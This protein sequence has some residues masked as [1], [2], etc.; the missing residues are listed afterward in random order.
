V[1]TLQFGTALREITPPYPAWLHGYADRDRPSDGVLEPT[2]LGCLAISNGGETA[3]ILTADMIGIQAHICQRLYGLLERATGIGYP[4]L[5][6]SCS[7]THFAPALHVHRYASPHVG[8]VDADPRFVADFEAKLVEAAQESLRNMQPGRLEG[9]RLAAPQVSFNRR[10]I[11][12]DGSVQTNF[13]YPLNPEA[14]TFSPTD[15]ELTVLRMRN[16]QGIG[17]VLCNFGCHPVT[18]GPSREG[19]HYRVSSDYPFYVRQVIATAYACPVFFTLGA[20][21]DAVPM[22]RY[23]DSRQRIGSILGNSAL[24]AERRYAADESTDIRAEAIT[25]AVDTIMETDPDLVEAEYEEARDGFLALFDDP[26]ADREG[27][28]YRTASA[29]FQEKGNAL[30]RSRLYPDNRYAIPVQFLKIGGTTLVGLPFEV[31]S[32]FSLRMKARFPHSVLVSCCG[33]Y[34]GYL[35]FAYEY[36]RGGYE[37]SARSTHFVPGT[38]DRLLEVVLDKLGNW[39]D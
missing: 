36:E 7:H 37:A 22:D 30:F 20:A 17:A 24:L 12:A 35:P 2:Y 28:A 1:G 6:L 29:S 23:G 19:D 10:T 14:Y 34:Q 21:G 15:T 33:G 26:D 5:L 38:A 32:E 13:R 25:V 11:K 31:L 39:R 8:L 3:L 16:A 9:V 4:H 27:E 18:G